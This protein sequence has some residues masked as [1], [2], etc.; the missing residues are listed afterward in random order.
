[1]YLFV[2]SL[3]AD[4]V[5]RLP[6][7]NHTHWQ[8]AKMLTSDRPLNVS[9]GNDAV[10]VKLPTD[11][12]AGTMPVI[13]LQF[14]GPLTIDEPQPAAGPLTLEPTSAQKFYN[15]NGRG[16]E[17]PK[18]LYKYRWIVR[19]GCAAL[20]FHVDGE[21]SVAMI[22]NGHARTVALKEGVHEQVTIGPDHTLEFTPPE[23]FEKGTP[24]A[25]AIHSIEF[26]PQACSG[27]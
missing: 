3:P 22:S 21:G 26:T 4:G 1:M 24:L 27:R 9:T 10:L 19:S 12:V 6:N 16:Y 11:A 15:Y 14:R 13:K 7:A 20:T 18:T 8:S 17:A 2:K 23:P 5:L 25:P